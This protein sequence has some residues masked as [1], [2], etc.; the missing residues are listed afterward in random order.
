MDKVYMARIGYVFNDKVQEY[1]RLFKS[2]DRAIEYANTHAKHGQWSDIKIM[3]ENI[4][5]E[6]HLLGWKD[7]QL[8]DVFI[9][10][11]SVY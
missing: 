6:Y 11:E 10:E 5:I 1:T 4:S 7:G 3:K 9:T 2:L 8:L